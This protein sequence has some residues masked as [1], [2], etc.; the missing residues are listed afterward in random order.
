M[1]VN[2]VGK[3]QKIRSKSHNKRNKGFSIREELNNYTVI[4]LET[5]GK[6]ITT[7]EIIEMS[8]VKIR[9]GKVADTFTTLVKTKRYFAKRSYTINWYNTR[10]A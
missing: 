8:A 9:F 10:Y 1:K 4:D 2:F 5:T 6:Y 7:C 3:H